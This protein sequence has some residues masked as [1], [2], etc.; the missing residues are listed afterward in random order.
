MI[1]SYVAG[2]G[3]SCLII[4]VTRVIFNDMY[5]PT[6]LS[7]SSVPVVNSIVRIPIQNS[8][9]RLS[10]VPREECSVKSSFGEYFQTSDATLQSQR[11][12]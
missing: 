12:C 4:W 6:R 8:I 3:L 1:S 9:Y 5:R 11:K 2:V 7:T 10:V